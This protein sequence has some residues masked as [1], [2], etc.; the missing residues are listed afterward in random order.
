MESP[1]EQLKKAQAANVELTVKVASMEADAAKAAVSLADATAKIATLEADLAKGIGDMAAVVQARDKAMADL[2]AT[3]AELANAKDTLSGKQ[4]RHVAGA[5]E[6]KAST[7]AGGGEAGEDK[8]F[9][10]KAD[11]LRAYDAVKRDPKAAQ[12]F[13]RQHWA[14]LGLPK[15]A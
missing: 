3:Q 13:R 9:A 4:F 11:A 14:I 6:G 5:A 10:S 15:P 1:I 7:V 2:T 12:D 8:P